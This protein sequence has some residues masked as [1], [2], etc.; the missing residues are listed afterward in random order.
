[1]VAGRAASAVFDIILACKK[2][3]LND[4]TKLLRHSLKGHQELEFS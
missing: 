1:M 3:A 4:V 2:W